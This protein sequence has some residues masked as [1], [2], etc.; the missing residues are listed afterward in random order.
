MTSLDHQFGEIADLDA[1]DGAE[2]KTSRAS[3]QSALD[4]FSMAAKLRFAV[5]GN[6]GLLAAL[7]LVILGGTWVLAERGRALAVV[8]S[9]EVRSAGA[10]I[11]LVEVI[12]ELDDGDDQQLSAKLANARANLDLAER[13]LIA[14]IEFAQGEMPPELQVRSDD[15]LARTQR[16]RDDLA[17]DGRDPVRRAQLADQAQ[18]LYD[19]ISVFA[20]ELRPIAA[21]QAEL[22]FGTIGRFLFTFAVCVVLGIALSTGAARL[23]LGNVI[24]TMRSITTAMKRIADGKTD[25]QIPGDH[26]RD[27]IGEMARA[28]TV[29][30]S[31]SMALRDL[32]AERARD[33]EK[34]LANEQAVNAK[35]QALRAE[36]SALLDGMASGFEV[37]VG[38]V[39][40]SV[41]AAADALRGTSTQMVTLAQQS[42]GQSGEA[43]DA[44]G[45]VTRNVTAAAAA[46]DEFALSINEISRQAGASA[47]LAREASELVGSANAKMSDLN[48]AAQ[49]IGEIASL[50]QTIAQRTNL[51]A[52]NASIEAARGGEAGRGFAVVASEVKELATQTSNA[53]QSVAEKIAAMQS[54]TEASANDLSSIVDQITKLEETSV[55][56]ATAV[57]Q[58]SIS[59]EDLARN[60]ET[61]AGGS[62]EVGD[63]LEEL[64]EASHATGDA[65]GD[66]LTNA[67]ALGRQADT[68]Q[69]KAGQFIA[70]V[71]RSSR[72]MASGE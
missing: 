52:L 43:S 26:R 20:V 11:A 27:E 33:A 8:S 19:E 71:Q 58:Q 53:T 10:A 32:T 42:V 72:K 51:L 15:F 66:V 45:A 5:F 41:Q 1:S 69:A 54:S 46:T 7:A 49:E 21:K 28:L 64:R 70:D 67:E 14:Q 30:R 24:G 23:V 60:I 38:E 68:L 2:S 37:S 55:V 61:V 9:V 39:I 50:I 35:D 22:L 29:F 48:Q 44:M 25:T 63:R 13:A 4:G 40:A 59:G 12:E 34:Q 62:S 17:S 3:F 18:A 57:D 56:I 31:S 36:Q 47:S 16:L 6:V 65:A